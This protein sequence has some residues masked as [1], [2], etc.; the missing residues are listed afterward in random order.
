MTQLVT[1]N[2]TLQ[3][4]LAHAQQ[5]LAQ[6]Q[7]YQ[8]TARQIELENAGLKKSLEAEQSQ[9][10]KTDKE[11][12][13]WRD[14]CN[15]SQ[16]QVQDLTAT[17]SE[18]T[19]RLDETDKRLVERGKLEE[20]FTATFESLSAKTLKS[21]QE[22]FQTSADALLKSRQE[23][24]EKLVQPLA[25]KIDSLDKARSANAA[26]FKEQ[27]DTM[28]RESKYLGDQ[29]RS[30]ADALKK[31]GV[32][33]RWGEIQLERIL[34]LSGLEKNTDYTVQDSFDTQGQRLRTDVVVRDGR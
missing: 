30:L 29:A 8:D 2:A 28:I 18:L 4:N 15:K 20:L 3:N 26:A 5:Q 11:R 1:G 12:E 9:H 21:Q 25:A 22:S 6:L 19:S 7:Q 34:E 16:K 13:N 27:I 14:Y 31:P 33:G 24:V 17:R 32:R 23:A 10:Q